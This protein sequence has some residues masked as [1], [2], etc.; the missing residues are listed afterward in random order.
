LRNITTLAIAGLGSLLCDHSMGTSYFGGVAFSV[1][2]QSGL[3]FRADPAVRLSASCTLKG[4]PRDEG[5]LCAHIGVPEYLN[6]QGE[7]YQ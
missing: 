6:V 3:G 1:T 7:L 4:H 5:I 2:V